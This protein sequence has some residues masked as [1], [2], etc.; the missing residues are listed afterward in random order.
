MKLIIKNHLFSLSGG[1][2]VNDEAGNQICKVKGKIKLFSPTRKKKVIDN[3]GNLQFVVKNKF[4]HFANFRTFI[5]DDEKN[6][7]AGVVNRT[8][9][10]KEPVAIESYSDELQFVG[11]TTRFS[12]INFDVEKNGKKIGHIQR[13]FNMLTDA[14]SLDVYDEKE[15]YFL[16][17]IVIA[18]DN[19][20]D[21]AREN[22]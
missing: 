9:N 22:N 6:K 14:F 1:S 10:F 15:V 4:W 2:Y 19:V 11:N 21:K 5:F 3:E 16:V 12:R 13:E 7:I 18:L 20:Q 8:W 17:A